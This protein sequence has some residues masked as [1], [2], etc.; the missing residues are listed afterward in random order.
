MKRFSTNQEQRIADVI[1]EIIITNNPWIDEDTELSNK[2]FDLVQGEVSEMCQN[3]FE[4][5]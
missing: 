2:W 1:Y 4:N 5:N 3:L